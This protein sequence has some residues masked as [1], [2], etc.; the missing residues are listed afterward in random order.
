[1]KHKI[2]KKPLRS[3]ALD[4]FLILKEVSSYT[5]RSSSES[6]LLEATMLSA[7]ALIR[8]R[9]RNSSL[10]FIT[11]LRSTTSQFRQF[12]V[13]KQKDRPMESH[14]RSTLLQDF[15]PEYLSVI[16]ES[17]GGQHLESHFKVVIVSKCFE[18]KRLLQ[19][20]K[21]VKTSLQD[22]DKNL[23]FHSL[24]IASYT[25]EQWKATQVIPR[26]PKCAGGDGLP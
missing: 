11:S 6:R 15:K 5:V 8:S 12:S 1:M 2:E 21:K 23:P 13:D 22:N 9:V 17:H 14:I 3:V 18:G 25:P 16:N 10:A 7:Q 20:H 24:S 4:T 19:Q 26:S